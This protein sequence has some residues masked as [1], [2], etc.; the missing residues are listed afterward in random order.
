MI[1]I[2]NLIYN[3]KV[4]LFNAYGAQAK[5]INPTTNTFLLDTKNLPSGIY[6][7]TIFSAQKLIVTKQIC[8][9]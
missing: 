2:S 4:I 1:A 8:I 6:F 9:N 7:L 5:V 3:P